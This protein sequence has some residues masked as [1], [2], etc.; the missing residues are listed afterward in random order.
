MATQSRSRRLATYAVE[1]ATVAT[2]AAVLRVGA[3]PVDRSSAGRIAPSATP[4]APLHANAVAQLLDQL[5]A[6]MLAARGDAPSVATLAGVLIVVL[7]LALATE[8]MGLHAL[9]SAFVAGAIMPPD[10]AL[11]RMP[12]GTACRPSPCFL[13]PLFFAFTGLRT[14]I[15]LIDDTASMDALP[16]DHRRRY[17]RKA[18]RQPLAARWTGM[19]W[20]ASSRSAPS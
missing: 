12:V 9:F 7:A 14:Q 3:R 11:R 2:L 6:R 16:R 18:G 1:I 20:S 15:G 4:A 10:G 5:P 13:L 8:A 19:N 17:A